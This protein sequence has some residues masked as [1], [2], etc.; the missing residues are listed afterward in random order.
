M[1][2]KPTRPVLERSYRYYNKKYFGN[3]LPNPPEVDIR[4]GDIQGSGY[5]VEDEIVISRK[6]RGRSNVWKLTL[7]HEM[8]HLSLNP[9]RTRSDHGKEFQSEMLRLAGAGAFRRLW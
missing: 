2:K 1:A 7:L 3:L 8:V 6:D 4:W 9:Y 5:Q